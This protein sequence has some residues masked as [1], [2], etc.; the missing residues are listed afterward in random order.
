[1]TVDHR[2]RDQAMAK[3]ATLVEALPWLE[4]FAGALVVIKYGGHAMVD[5][6]LRAA[7]AQDVVF[8]RCAGLRPV[9]VHGGVPRSARCWTGSASSRSSAE[10][11]A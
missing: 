7:F 3:A 6:E 4:R 2:A 5:P 1:M 9:V 8:L 10:V 11:C